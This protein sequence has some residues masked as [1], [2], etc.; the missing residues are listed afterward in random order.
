MIASWTLEVGAPDF[1]S[2]LDLG[3]EYRGCC[4]GG[5]RAQHILPLAGSGF[6]IQ[7]AVELFTK[8]QTA[9]FPKANYLGK[10]MFAKCPSSTPRRPT[11]DVEVE[12]SFFGYSRTP[13]D[14]STFRSSAGP[15]SEISHKSISLPP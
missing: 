2:G 8:Q 11:M 6:V 7:L 10:Y 5:F 12:A 9:A 3:T 14:V 4:R 1:V 13:V 15:R